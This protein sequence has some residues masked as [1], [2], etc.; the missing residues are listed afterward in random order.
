MNESLYVQRERERLFPPLP[1][2]SLSLILSAGND[3][4]LEM[5]SCS[6]FFFLLSAV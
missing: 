2:P 1:Y 6:F 3:D 5:W 4:T